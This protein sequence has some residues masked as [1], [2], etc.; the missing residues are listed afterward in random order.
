MKSG[1]DYS[2]ALDFGFSG[3]LKEE[4]GKVFANELPERA[5]ARKVR[6]APK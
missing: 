1:L 6:D 2:L 4:Y 5:I 3:A